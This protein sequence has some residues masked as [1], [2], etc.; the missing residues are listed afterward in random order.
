M[1]AAVHTMSIPQQCALL[2]GFKLYAH[3]TWVGPCA[4]D[5]GSALD[6]EKRGLSQV[7]AFISWPG[8]EIRLAPEKRMVRL[9]TTH[10]K[11]FLPALMCPRNHTDKLVYSSANILSEPEV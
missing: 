8:H 4:L 2:Q 6:A 9:S 5:A 1:H 11:R 10:G 3:I 7:L